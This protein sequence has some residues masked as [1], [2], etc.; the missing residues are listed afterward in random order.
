MK[1]KQSKTPFP[2]LRKY[3]IGNSTYI[4]K[5]AIKDNVTEDAISK[6]RRLILNDINKERLK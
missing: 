6:T 5:A 4:V 3:L 2:V 1:T